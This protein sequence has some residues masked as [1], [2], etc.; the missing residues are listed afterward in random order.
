MDKGVTVLSL[1]D[2]ISC[3]RIALERAGIEVAKYY[4]SEIKKIA[5]ETTMLHYPDTIQIGDVTK[6]SYENGVL[7]TEKGQ[8]EIGN[9]DLLIGG[10]PCQDFSSLRA[11]SGLEI[12]G[13][14][15]AKS[16]L[17]YEYLRLLSEV[18][19]RFFLLE[20][21]RMKRESEEQLNE[22]LGVKGIFIN[23]ILVSYQNR[24]RIYWTNIPNVVPPE[25]RKINFQTFRERDYQKQLP[26]KVNRT[27][28]RER[29]W[30]NGAGRNQAGACANVTHSD[31]IQCITRKQDRF[32]NSGLIEFDGFCRYLTREELERGQTL[33][34]GYTDNLTYNQMQDVCGDCWTV[35]VISHIF[36]FAKP[37]I[38]QTRSAWLDELLGG[39]EE[40]D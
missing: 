14:E 30:N 5:I 33:P 3:G 22:Y 25:D 6:V 20:N 8:F 15:G 1:F 32:L 34:I 26:Y 36:R 21:V 16:K 2:G 37:Y 7:Y 28:S 23:S 39:D 13:L 10:S 31:H 38:S 19:P 29:M 11:V 4:A 17:F 18:K 12:T 35:D 9:V 27:P 40:R 24:P